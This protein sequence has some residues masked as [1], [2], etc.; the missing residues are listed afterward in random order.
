MQQ[1][2]S[3]TEPKIDPNSLIQQLCNTASIRNFSPNTSPIR[4]FN[5]EFHSRQSNLDPY[6]KAFQ[7]AN[8]VTSSELSWHIVFA[9]LLLPTPP[10]TRGLWDMLVL[11]RMHVQSMPRKNIE[12][13]L[14]NK[15]YRTYEET[16]HWYEH[17]APVAA[18]HRVLTLMSGQQEFSTELGHKKEE[19]SLPWATTKGLRQ[20]D[21]IKFLNGH[22]AVGEKFNPSCQTYA[23]MWLLW[24][25]FAFLRNWNGDARIRVNSVAGVALRL[26]RL[27]CKWFGRPDLLDP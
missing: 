22:K 24:L 17:E 25:Q 7:L 27:L 10:W 19:G 16:M 3:N 12:Q 26:M 4:P 1:A 6:Q 2:G 21:M 14:T 18:C 23:A 9:T 20:E 8:T 13:H 11:H 5:P 15:L